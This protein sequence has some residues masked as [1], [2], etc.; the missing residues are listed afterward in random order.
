MNQS[1]NIDKFLHKPSIEKN[2]FDNEKINYFLN[3]KN[4]AYSILKKKSY[5][6]KITNYSM[7]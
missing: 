1:K 3:K 7:Y 5:Y 4:E 2:I 6:L